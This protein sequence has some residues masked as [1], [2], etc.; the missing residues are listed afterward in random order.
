M[1]DVASS[2]SFLVRR[3]TCS[4]QLDFFLCHTSFHKRML[5]YVIHGNTTLHD[6]WYIKTEYNTVDNM[7]HGYNLWRNDLGA[8]THF[9]L[10]SHFM[11][12]AKLDLAGYYLSSAYLYSARLECT[13]RNLTEQFHQSSVFIVF[14][15]RT[16]EC[17]ATNRNIFEMAECKI[18][19]SH[20]IQSYLKHRKFLWTIC[21]QRNDST[22]TECN[23]WKIDNI[24]NFLCFPGFTPIN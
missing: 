14:S 11:E 15:T 6:E 8:L 17:T 4:F 24:L 9:T 12:Q 5:P 13:T 21:V 1:A 16:A 10:L 3:S 23:I 22:L 19:I 18:L 2:F 20:Q 7:G